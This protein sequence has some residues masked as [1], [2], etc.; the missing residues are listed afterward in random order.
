M[1]A[2]YLHDVIS[3]GNMLTS[4]G[5]VGDTDTVIKEVRLVAV[6]DKSAIRYELEQFADIHAYDVV[7]NALVIT[8]EGTMYTLRGNEIAVN[9]GILTPDE[10]TGSIVV[11]NHP[12]NEFHG[13]G[14]SFSRE[15]LMFAAMYNLGRQY[16]VS[17]NFRSSYSFTTPQTVENVYNAWNNAEHRMMEQAKASGKILVQWQA[18]IMALISAFLEGIVCYDW[19]QD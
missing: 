15:D 3:N 1:D 4:S 14:D 5:G 12:V 17:G 11:H 18:E 9:P 13:M 6:D 19:F 7:E 2:V 8:P 10:L 16:I